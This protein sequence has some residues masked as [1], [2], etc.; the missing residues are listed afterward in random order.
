MHFLNFPFT[1]SSGS[2]AKIKAPIKLQGLSNHTIGTNYSFNY[3]WVKPR[4]ITF[5][6]NQSHFR[7]GH[8]RLLQLDTE[9]NIENDNEEFCIAV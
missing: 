1:F 2:L 5:P 9:G 8:S 4:L 3:V 7:S 6:L